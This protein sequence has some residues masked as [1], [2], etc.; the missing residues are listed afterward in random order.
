VLTAL[1]LVISLILALF[2]AS[3]MPRREASE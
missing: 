2:Y 1:M 3:F